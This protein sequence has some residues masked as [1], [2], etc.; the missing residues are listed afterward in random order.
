MSVKGEIDMRFK[1]VYCRKRRDKVSFLFRL[2]Y[3]DD[4]P[5][6][7]FSVKKTS[8]NK[9]NNSKHS[10]PLKMLIFYL[11]MLLQMEGIIHKK[12]G[13]VLVGSLLIM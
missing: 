9:K 2:S 5:K 10:V 12:H 13:G 3:G 8:E 7:H 4:I 1:T 11:Y 6:H